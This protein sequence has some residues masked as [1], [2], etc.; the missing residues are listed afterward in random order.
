[1]TNCC[2]CN[3][4]ELWVTACFSLK[5]SCIVL[6]LPLCS[7]VN[8]IFTMYIPACICLQVAIRLLDSDFPDEHVRTF[9]VQALAQLPDEQLEDYLLQLVQVYHI[10]NY[11][12]YAVWEW[13]NN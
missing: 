3:K 12:T 13:M 7:S 11:T 4:E 8:W 10:H 5:L 2:S 1:M 9:A 6:E